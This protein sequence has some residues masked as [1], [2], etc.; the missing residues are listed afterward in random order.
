[1]ASR[2]SCTEFAH[3][4]VL[5]NARDGCGLFAVGGGFSASA[6]VFVEPACECFHGESE[7][8]PHPS[9]QVDGVEVHVA[10]EAV[11]EVVTRVHIDQHL[12]AAG[13]EEAEAAVADLRRRA[14]AA[15]G[16]D[17]EGHGQVVAESAEQ[18]GG[19]HGLPFQ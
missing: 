3:A 13:A 1:M 5:A 4:M 7:V 6:F 12:V 10:V 9:H 17:D 19:G 2:P 8:E 18:F 14:I 16:G 11:G 15:E